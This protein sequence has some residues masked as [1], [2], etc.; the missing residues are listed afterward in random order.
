[1]IEVERSPI[2]LW[3]EGLRVGEIQ[4]KYRNRFL[5]KKFFYLFIINHSIINGLS[6]IIKFYFFNHRNYHND[7]IFN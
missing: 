4:L 5:C 3:G 7:D 1:M 2:T 6:S